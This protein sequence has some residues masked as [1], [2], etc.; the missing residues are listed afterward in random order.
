MPIEAQI[1]S[2][3]RAATT[4]IFP[5]TGKYTLLVM[6]ATLMLGFSVAV[7]RELLLSAQPAGAVA[8]NR[9]AT[10]RAGAIEARPADEEQAVAKQEAKQAPLRANGAANEDLVPEAGEQTGEFSSLEDVAAYLGQRVEE[11]GGFRTLLAGDVAVADIHAEAVEFVIVLTEMGA[12]VVVVDWSL[13]GHGAIE[14]EAASGPGLIDLLAGRV[15]FEDVVSTLP[16]TRVHYIAAGTV[17]SE[18]E[19]PLD[20]DGLN[21]ILDALDEAYDHVVVVARYENAQALFEAI[22]GRFDAGITIEPLDGEVDPEVPDDQFLDFEVAEIEL[23]RYRPAVVETPVQAAKSRRVA[24]VD[25][26]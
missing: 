22:E 9:R 21:L 8:H 6:A 5:L 11:D 20:A 24:L 4:P 26:V 10:D 3:A 2:R 15:S 12:S 14:T 23:I 7:T 13:D 18:D 1:E 25:A 17:R 19:D 16:G